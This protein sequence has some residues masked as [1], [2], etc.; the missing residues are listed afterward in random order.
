MLPARHP[1]TPYT[2]D[3][4]LNHSPF[5][6]DG[7]PLKVRERVHRVNAVGYGPLS[8]AATASPIRTRCRARPL[9]DRKGTCITRQDG[10]I[11]GA[12]RNRTARCFVGVWFT[13]R[14]VCRIPH[15]PYWW[16]LPG[17]NWRHPAC[18]AGALPTEL[19]A[20]IWRRLASRNK[21]AMLDLVIAPRRSAKPASETRPATAL[22]RHGEDVSQ[23]REF[24]AGCGSRTRLD[25]LEG[26]CTSPIC[27]ARIF[28][29]KFPTPS[30]QIVV[31]R[32]NAE[33][34]NAEKPHSQRLSV[35]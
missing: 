19:K 4:Y 12:P 11:G 28:T 18:R 27:Q 23:L 29:T 14:W 7:L 22:A 26:Y 10:G 30:P 32:R 24:G 25:S 15:A 16:T 8:S 17:S 5:Q 31:L 33:K 6:A 9:P 35:S 1:I 20:R 21:S 13:A 3:A 2:T 34:R